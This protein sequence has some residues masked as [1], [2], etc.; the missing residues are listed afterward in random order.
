MLGHPQNGTTP[1]MANGKS[2]DK[3]RFIKP[4]VSEVSDLMPLESEVDPR[5]DDFEPPEFFLRSYGENGELHKEI[6]LKKYMP[7]YV[8]RAI[9]CIIDLLE[10]SI[11]RRHC[12]FQY[13]ELLIDHMGNSV[14]GYMLY[15]LKSSHG[16]FLN[17][18]RI[19]SME[20]IKLHHGDRI[21]LGQ[22]TTIFTFFDSKH[23][24]RGTEK[25]RKE[26]PEA[27]TVAVQ[28]TEP[29]SQAYSDEMVTQQ[30]SSTSQTGDAEQF[31][32]DP[33]LLS[34]TSWLQKYIM[35][36][37]NLADSAKEYEEYG[38]PVPNF[39]M[40]SF[41][42]KRLK[43]EHTKLVQQAQIVAELLA[44][45]GSD[46]PQLEM[47][48]PEETIKRRRKRKP[49]FTDLEAPP[50]I[51]TKR[52]RK[53]KI[54]EDASET[55]VAPVA[56]KKRR[57]R[58]TKAEILAD[59]YR[60]SQESTQLMEDI[61]PLAITKS[62]PINQEAPS[63]KRRRQNKVKNDEQGPVAILP[64][65]KKERKKPGRKPKLTSIPQNEQQ[66]IENPQEFQKTPPTRKK[67]MGRP[68]RKFFEPQFNSTQQIAPTEPIFFNE[69]ENFL[70]SPIIASQTQ[71]QQV[72]VE[73]QQQQAPPS[74]NPYK[75]IVKNQ[76]RILLQKIL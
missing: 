20:N 29:V 10:P 74:G 55:P 30:P 12:V 24:E 34:T 56:V 37:N 59:M 25:P 36:L 21:K 61:D 52:V 44:L 76:P 47:P 62:E 54:I 39:D 63:R 38:V 9:G 50:P 49:K 72:L 70:A 33:D 1:I 71:Q 51:T 17:D 60:S 69:P 2:A 73:Q 5:I 16:T 41:L 23:N 65:I 66:L 68:A 28:T 32:H 15:D 57:K 67:K 3:V 64:V 45:I 26:P 7:V 58:R 31:L 40:D 18:E 35:I 4:N 53:P 19:P 11:S 22:C 46:D 13:K 6:A 43:L 75:T 14:S 27:T 8:G 42:S 48:P